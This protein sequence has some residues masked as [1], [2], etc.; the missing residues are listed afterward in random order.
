MSWWNPTETAYSDQRFQTLVSLS[1]VFWVIPSSLCFSAASK[2]SRR[3]FLGELGKFLMKV[4]PG[5][6]GKNGRNR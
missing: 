4:D 6:G 3:Q 5:N 2:S 1:F